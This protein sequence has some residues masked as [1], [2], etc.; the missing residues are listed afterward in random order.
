MQSSQPLTDVM[1]K[2]DAP[3]LYRFDFDA[4]KAAEQSAPTEW[5]HS[6]VQ[7]RDVDIKAAT[8]NPLSSD[9]SDTDWMYTAS[10]N[11]KARTSRR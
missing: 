2:G 3:H 11:N 6:E 9:F 1:H 4:L 7:Q 8:R 5:E 10:T